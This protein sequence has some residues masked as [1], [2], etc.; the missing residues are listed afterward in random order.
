[1]RRLRWLWLLLTVGCSSIATAPPDGFDLTG[2]WRLDAAASDVAPA[3]EHIV[4][5]EHRRLP[6]DGARGP[7][8]F[9]PSDFPLL[10]ADTLV[11]EQD[12]QS[13]GIE[14]VGLG[15][16]DV[17]FG[18]REWGGWKIEAGW[19]D[20]GE[21]RVHMKRRGTAYEE[22]YRLEAGGARLVVVATVDTRRG[23]RTVTRLFARDATSP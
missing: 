9:R 4:E 21:L 12:P 8:P 14:Y 20:A 23:E 17:T 18:E 1:M 5:P 22:R 3:R 16:R 6:A 7:P 15:Y 2:V 10:L 13:M 11:I 19:D